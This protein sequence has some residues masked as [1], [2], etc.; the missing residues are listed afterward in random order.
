M[1]AE[2][3]LAQKEISRETTADCKLAEVGKEA[4]ASS[5][6]DEEE[7]QLIISAITQLSNNYTPTAASAAAASSS[8]TETPNNDTTKSTKID[9][10]NNNNEDDDTKVAKKRKLEEIGANSSASKV[11]AKED[12]RDLLSLA[13][14]AL[15][16][17]SQSTSSE[18]C[19]KQTTRYI[20]FQIEDEN[21]IAVKECHSDKVKMMAQRH[22][23]ACNA[24][25]NK[26][27]KCYMCFEFASNCEASFDAHLRNHQLD[28]I[29][30]EYCGKSFN[31]LNDYNLH[32]CG[33]VRAMSLNGHGH[34]RCAADSS[35]KEPC[36]SLN[37]RYF[38]CLLCY[39]N[40]KRQRASSYFYTN[41]DS[42]RK[43]LFLKHNQNLEI[44]C[45]LCSDEAPKE[46]NNTI[47]IKNYVH[48]LRNVHAI[49]NLKCT[50][51]QCLQETT[52][53]RESNEENQIVDAVS[54]T[55]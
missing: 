9:I 41:Y 45:S 55:S 51:A 17:H 21:I 48:H 31:Y 37:N 28:E 34:H 33:R 39:S 44:K 53:A 50:C 25:S 27:H 12:T 52:D 22:T 6:I 15:N 24:Y 38:I 18:S 36:R 13:V 43:H 42:Y 7:A 16:Q 54:A 19:S 14:L 20:K 11:A 10:N 30:C 26:K 5:N 2:T 3:E 35:E 32:E 46:P 8:T 1:E 4:K 23:S 47:L 29:E 40:K 49:S